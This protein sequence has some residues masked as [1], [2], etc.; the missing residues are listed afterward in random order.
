MPVA[1]AAV[2]RKVGLAVYHRRI[3]LGIETQRE[4]ADR[5]GV[6]LNTVSRLERGTPSKRRNPTWSAIEDALDWPEGMIADMAAGRTRK[7][8]VELTADAVRQ[9]VIGAIHDMELNVTV[10]QANQ[11][12]AI[13]V[14]RL[15][16]QGMLPG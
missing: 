15:K 3:E 7:S 1:D 16:R 9:A 8:Q 14:E 13:T 2:W 12:A 4:L 10:P 11:I 6:H 5:A